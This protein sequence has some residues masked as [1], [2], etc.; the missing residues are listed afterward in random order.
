MSTGGR[1]L[2]P[3]IGLAFLG[4]VC[5]T[6]AVGLVAGRAVAACFIGGADFGCGFATGLFTGLVGAAFLAGCE[7]RAAGFFFALC[8]LALGG[9]A[10]FAVA[11]GLL[12]ADCR[13]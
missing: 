13:M 7:V 6:G 9:A 10:V 11:R 1:I 5:A 2:P 12:A 3:T 8:G 4:F